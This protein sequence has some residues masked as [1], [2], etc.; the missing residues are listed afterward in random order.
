V[1]GREPNGVIEPAEYEKFRDEM[2]AK[3]EATTDAE[4][5]N[6]GTLVFKPNE[7]YNNVKNVAPDLIVHFGAL[8]WRSIGGVGYHGR[9]HIRENDTG[10]DDCNHAQLGA[11]ILAGANIPPLGE[12]RGAH[13]LD[14][15]PTLMEVG[16]YGIPETFQGK[17]L[18]AG[19]L[20]DTEGAALSSEAEEIIRQRLSG[21]GYIS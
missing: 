1:K 6:I 20:A 9:L 15:A 10:P 19:S 17:S 2:K 14:M 18:F 5:N 16:G 3:F 12:L 13:L 21:L 8:D 7:I 11:F 4:G